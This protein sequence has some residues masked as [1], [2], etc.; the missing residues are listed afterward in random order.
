M[1]LKRIESDSTIANMK[2]SDMVSLISLIDRFQ[3]LQQDTS[4]ERVEF[5]LSDGE[6]LVKFGAV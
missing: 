6:T 2:S 3:S 5:Q 4:F 1:Y